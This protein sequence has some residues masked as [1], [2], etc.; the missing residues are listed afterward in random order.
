MAPS[1]SDPAPLSS[2]SN[3]Q[4]STTSAPPK[5]VR[6]RLETDQ[7]NPSSDM[8]EMPKKRPKVAFD[9]DVRIKVLHG[10]DDDFNLTRNDVRQV[11][12]RHRAG[13]D[14][15]YNR[16][17]ELFT[18]RPGAENA[19]S[20]ASLRNHLLALTSVVSRLG[21]FCS[22]LVHAILDCQWLGR[23]EPFVSAYIRFVGS[24]VSAQGAYVGAVL[25]MLV[26]D[27]TAGE[28]SQPS[29]LPCTY[30]DP[31]SASVLGHTVR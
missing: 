22:D 30:A 16:L 6:P 7:E 4:V 12:E 18:T 26:D 13:D 24:L 5:K 29:R 21:R 20:S 31:N 8:H 10:W 19:P 25:N 1:L 14:Q 11:I 3:S 23:E 2:M 17:K 9:S 15:G 28:S 27:M